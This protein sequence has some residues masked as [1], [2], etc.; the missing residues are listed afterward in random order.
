[1]ELVALLALWVP[2]APMVDA[3][4]L[5]SP[6]ALLAAGLWTLHYVNRSL[7]YPL[8][9]RT[10][11]KRM[12]VVI[13]LFAMLFNSVNGYLNGAY[14]AADQLQG[15]AAELLDP[16][17][18]LGLLT[19]GAGW[20]V[21][22]RADNTLLLLRKPSETGY[23]I[24]RGSLFERISCPNFLGEIVQWC[25]FAILCWNLPSFAFAVWTAANL[26]PRG[27]AHHRW[28]LSTFEDY[29][30]RRKAIFPGLL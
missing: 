16:R 18:I 14:I 5:P 4:N 7:V 10:V 28:Y 11:A 19:F 20:W 26:I 8:R 3:G 2:L 15:A 17:T 1:M 29:P 22:L 25:G 6:V 12:P 13:M 9:T 30:K 21:N 27:L 23:R 24:P